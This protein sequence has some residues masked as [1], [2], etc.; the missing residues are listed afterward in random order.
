MEGFDLSTKVYLVRHAASDS[1]IR[2]E[3]TRPLTPKGLAD[4]E[5][6]TR[7]LIDKRITAIYSSPYVRAVRTVSGLASS[8]GIP[9]TTVH[10]LRE[11]Q[12][13]R[14]VG[15]FQ[16]Y[17]RRMWSD[18]DY[19]LPDGESLSEVQQRNIRALEVIIRSNR[20][21]NVAVGTHGTAMGVIINHYDRS[22]GFEQWASLA[23]PDIFVLELDDNGTAI[24]I[25]RLPLDP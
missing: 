1:T 3:Y 16:E 5:R 18:F 15:D 25:E 10:D 17:A 14:W 23:M 11:R 24:S 21:G 19:R 8:L 2:D 12:T 20:G 9:I 6:V 7:A 4:V 22:F 13:G